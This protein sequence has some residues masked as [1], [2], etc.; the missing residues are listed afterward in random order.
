MRR[1]GDEQH[2]RESGNAE[3]V[4][5]RGDRG[6]GGEVKQNIIARA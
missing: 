1:T 3:I 2:E 6:P 4:T 5:V